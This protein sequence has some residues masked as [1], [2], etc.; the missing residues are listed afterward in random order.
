MEQEDKLEKETETAGS[1]VLFCQ[2]NIVAAVARETAT[3]ELAC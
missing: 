2:L 3:P 1:I